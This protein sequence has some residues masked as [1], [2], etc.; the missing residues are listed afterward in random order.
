[1]PGF[2]G[3]LAVYDDIARSQL[4]ALFPDREIVQVMTRDIIR[5]G[6]NIH[7]IT[8]QMPGV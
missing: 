1:M 3:D 4:A 8:Q 2:G 7:C 6:G 5:G